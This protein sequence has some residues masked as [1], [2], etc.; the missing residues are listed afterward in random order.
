MNNSSPP[1]L[2][3]LHP[4]LWRASQ[5]ARSTTRCIDAGFPALASELG[6]AGWPTGVL[7]DLLVQ[8]AGIGEI[9]LLAPALSK[10]ALRQIVLIQ[11]P[12]TPQALGMATLGIP[13]SSLL[14]VKG[15]STA[16]A[17]WAAE[18]VL[19]SGS[20]GALLFWLPHVRAESLRR[21]HLAAQSGETLFYVLRPLA[22]AQDP[23][24]AP[25]R[26]S[27]RPAPS[28]IEIEFIKRRGP[29]RSEPLFVPLTI[30]PAARPSVR[31]QQPVPPVQPLQPLPQSVEAAMPVFVDALT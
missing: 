13:P 30:G 21:L 19:R 24:P 17:L 28:G 2:E 6:G 8:Q 11:P 7:I 18:Q 1:S 27:L 26:L 25:L 31:P 29:Q 3:S 9:R 23:C 12:Q 4:S 10:V 22:A 5:L 14:W 15:P 16:D 20:C